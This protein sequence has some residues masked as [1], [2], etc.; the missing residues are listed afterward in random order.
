MFAKIVF[1]P[2]TGA[3]YAAKYG[4]KYGMTRYSSHKPRNGE[5]LTHES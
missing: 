3:K 4:A 5:V 1:L 2:D